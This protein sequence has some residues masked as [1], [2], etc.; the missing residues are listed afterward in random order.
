MLKVLTGSKGIH[1][2]GGK[3]FFPEMGR[4]LTLPSMV[5]LNGTFHSNLE[6]YPKLVLK[7]ADM[8]QL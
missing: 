5:Y 8:W 7:V 3:F 1:H 4:L 2:G 6:R